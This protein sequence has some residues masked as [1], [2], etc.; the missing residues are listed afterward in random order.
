MAFD[1]QKW[2]VEEMGFPADEAKDLA[3]KF[4]DRSEKIE[5]GYLRQSDYSKSM[6]DLKKTQ[7]DLAAAEGKLNGEMAQWAELTAAEKAEAGDLKAKLDA[8][9]AKIFTMQQK[10]TRLAEDAGIDPKTVLDGEPVVPSKKDDVKPFDPGP[11]QQQIGGVAKYMLTLTA[12]LPRIQREYKQLT[13]EDFDD[14]AF[15]SGIENDIAENKKGA[16]LDP[17]ARYEA[18]FQIPEKRKVAAEAAI[19]GRIK[20]A[21]AEERTAVL[22]EAALPNAGVRQGTHSPIF[23]RPSAATGSVLHRPQPGQRTGT[24]AALASGK[25]RHVEQKTA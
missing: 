10:L 15:I 8:S 20:Q 17:I 25:Y 3:P 23:Q 7:T 22:S 5:K 11:L 12:K 13:G 6:N 14:D 9:E 2:L 4:A 19:E 16:I 18:L 24:A 1:T 21:R